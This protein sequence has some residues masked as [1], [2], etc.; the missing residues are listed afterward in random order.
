MAAIYPSI[1]TSSTVSLSA[2]TDSALQGPVNNWLSER[3][4]SSRGE[5]GQGTS[6]E[7]SAEA[8]DY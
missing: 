6:Y 5:A 2:S 3:I 4:V 8:E 1:A 7:R